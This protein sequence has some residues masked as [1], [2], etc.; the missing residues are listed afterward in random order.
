MSYEPQLVTLES[1]V[2]MECL[3]L[4]Q[5]GTDHSNTRYTHTCKD[6]TLEDR[7]PQQFLHGRCLYL[8]GIVGSCHHGHHILETLARWWPLVT[9]PRL[10]DNVDYIV[11]G[12]LW[13]DKSHRQL[14]TWRMSDFRGGLSFDRNNVSAKNW[15]MHA[16]KAFLPVQKHSL[17]IVFAFKPVKCDT[18]IIPE[19]LMMAGAALPMCSRLE[20]AKNLLG[21]LYAHLRD[22]YQ[23]TDVE[24][25][26]KIYLT[27]SSGLQFKRLRAQKAKE[28]KVP[29]CATWRFCSNE[30][31]LENI[32]S[33]KG[34]KIIT[35]EN[36]PLP[37]QI[38]LVANAKVIVAGIGTSSHNFVFCQDSALMF[39]LGDMND[40]D[41]KH[42]G[43]QIFLDYVSCHQPQRVVGHFLS[44]DRIGQMFE[45]NLTELMLGLDK[46]QAE[47]QRAPR[48]FY[49]LEPNWLDVTNKA[50]N[51]CLVDGILSF[52]LSDGE[53]AQLF[54]DP[55]PGRIK[56]IRFQQNEHVFDFPPGYLVQF[57]V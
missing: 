25:Y 6:F 17:P 33:Q 3:I 19:S 44:V 36:H 2:V 50:M 12:K 7:S 52:P 46:A 51:L 8:G 49:G 5:E 1:A 18:L 14:E 55:I 39:I 35:M 15:A 48:I 45:Y 26:E 53:R 47:Y 31:A 27:R 54:G 10:L 28:D 21:Q 30:D 29:L 41:M 56:F 42:Q 24:R 9:Q 22:F 16:L 40:P 32:L 57:K 43:A 37:E 13:A 4:D 20:T 38:A 34:F 11:I 23:P